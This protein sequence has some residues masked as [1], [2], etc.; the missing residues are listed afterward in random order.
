MKSPIDSAA[1]PPVDIAAIGDEIDRLL[2]GAAEQQRQMVAARKQQRRLR[3]DIVRA[4]LP[5]AGIYFISDGMGNIKIGYAT[6]PVD[7]VR[8]LQVGNAHTLRLILVVPGPASWERSFHQSW[9]S[10]RVRGEW[11]RAEEQLLA[12]IDQR[13]K[14]DMPAWWALSLEAA[15]EAADRLIAERR[16]R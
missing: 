12:H 7:R 1:P 10:L 2:V 11:F 15:E 16:G 9:S 5:P 8:Q 6:N 3:D 14:V 13:V 4:L